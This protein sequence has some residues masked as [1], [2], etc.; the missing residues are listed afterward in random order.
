MIGRT[1][2]G[3]MGYNVRKDEIRDNITRM[4]RQCEEERDSLAAVRR[5][6]P[7]CRPGLFV[8]VAENRRRPQV[9]P[10]LAGHQL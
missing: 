4:R 6:M 10:S 9:Q 8:V 3:L 1:P 7:S 2:Q 5:S